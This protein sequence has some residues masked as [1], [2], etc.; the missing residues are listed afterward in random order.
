MLTTI[1]HSEMGEMKSEERD[2]LAAL[3]QIITKNFYEAGTA[4]KEIRD[5]RL[6]RENFPSFEEYLKKTWGEGYSKAYVYKLIAAA[7]TINTLKGHFSED[8][9]PTTE[10]QC[11]PLTT[12]DKRDIPY[13][14][15]EIIESNQKPTAPQIKEE[16]R[17]QERYKPGAQVLITEG[18]HAGEEATVIKQSAGC[19]TLRTQ[20]DL[21][22]T[23][24][25]G[26]V[27]P[28]DQELSPTPSKRRASY[29]DLRELL[30]KIFNSGLTDELRA[31][32]A[33]ELNITIL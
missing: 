8:E 29:S 32:I 28:I 23:L 4:F 21:I 6:Y 18:T 9:L 5:A 16:I 22:D 12:L 15:G 3:E 17:R 14:W 2:R 26:E 25:I 31:R 7:D 11:R 33:Y 19:L 24:T 20:D 13:V 30:L 1:E 10:A 27:T